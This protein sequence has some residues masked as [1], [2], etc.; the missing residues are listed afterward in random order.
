MLWV[1]FGIWHVCRMEMAKGL[2]VSSFVQLQP[3]AGPGQA[4]DLKGRHL[5]PLSSSKLTS[6]CFYP[7]SLPVSSP[8]SQFILPHGLHFIQVSLSD[9]SVFLLYSALH[10]PLAFFQ[11][12]FSFLS[13]L[14][15]LFLL[16]VSDCSAFLLD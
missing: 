6:P 5:I 9:C 15:S 11:T 16:F 7:P 8:F 13:V 10:F 2:C 1:S 4:K 14:F 3:Q 12:F